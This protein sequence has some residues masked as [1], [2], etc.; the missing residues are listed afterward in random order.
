MNTMTMQTYFDQPKA[1]INKAAKVLLVLSLFW[2]PIST[3]ATNVFMGLTLIAW[4]LSGGF[5]ARWESLRGNWFAYATVGLFLMMCVGSLWSTGSREDILFQLHKYAKLLFMLPAI[6]LMQDEKWRQRGLAA[7]GLAMLLTLALS[8]ISVVWPLSFVKGTAGGPSE[9]HFVFRDHIAQ[10]LMM[11]FFALLA[12]TK[13]QFDNAISKRPLWLVLA[14]LSVI[15]ILF[16]VHGRTGYVSLAFNAVVFIVFLP[17]HSLRIISA[18]AMILI[19]LLANQYSNNFKSRINLAVTEYQEQD[20]KKLTSIGQRME[21]LKKGMHL[22]QERPLFGFGTGAYHKEFCRVAETQEWCLAGGFHPHNQFLAFGVQLGIAGILAY[23]GYL[24]IC[25]W[26]VLK[27]SSESRVLGMG[28]VA[29]LVADS[30]FHAPLFL[31]AEAAFFMLLFP[32]FMATKSST[33]DDAA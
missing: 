5:R 2:M 18:L 8:L 28:L 3:A 32:I 11:S 31:I 16:F 14:I 1:R 7:F 13:W 27:T 22:I 21:F 20:E 4:L 33:A 6:T 10:N 24:A 12:A 19:A 26:Q 29:T 23:L 30:I 17:T 25:V 9:N 15:D